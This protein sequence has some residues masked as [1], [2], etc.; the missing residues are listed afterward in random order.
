MLGVME[1]GVDGDSE[2]LDEMGERRM[3]CWSVSIQYSKLTVMAAQEAFRNSFL[4]T[5]RGR[6]ST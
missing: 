1:A 3:R 2:V 5:A 6:E 4:D